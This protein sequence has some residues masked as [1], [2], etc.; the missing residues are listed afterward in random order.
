ML[1]KAHLPKIPKAK[2]LRSN[3]HRLSAIRLRGT[4]P[5]D[6]PDDEDLCAS[7]SRRPKVAD[8]K[9]VDADNDEELS[10]YVKIRL[11]IARTRAMQKYREA[12]G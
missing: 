7:S 8:P 6:A 12:Q 11:L 9:P 10:D 4:S 1:P 5:Y 2:L 3:P